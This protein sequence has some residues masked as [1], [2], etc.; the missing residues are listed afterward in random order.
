[1]VGP[2]PSGHGGVSQ[3]VRLWQSGGYYD[4]FSI[5]YFSSV[6]QD[7]HKV[8]TLL[9]NLFCFTLKC[10][11]KCRFVYV[12]TSSYNSFYRKSLFI[13]LAYLFNKKLVI[14][15]HPAFFSQF[16]G[17]LSG[18]KRQIA[19]LIFSK[20]KG[21]IVLT[22]ELKKNISALFPDKQIF[23]L[24]NP[25]DIEGMAN[26]SNIQRQSSHILYLGWYVK[27]KGVY[28]LVDAIGILRNKNIDVTADFY[29]T[30]E[31]DDLR[32]YVQERNL[33][34]FVHINGWI[35]LNEKL[36]ALYSCTMLVLPSHTEGVPNV[37]LEA[38]ATKTPIISTHVGGL[39]D[40][41]RD[42]ENA[43]IAESKNAEDL[44][45]KIC[46]IL[47]DRTLSEK[48]SKSAYEEAC[49]NHS[50]PVIKEHFRLIL[51]NLKL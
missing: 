31:G 40:V 14:H 42:R 35:G 39:K 29:G 16:L 48:I 19:M 34:D 6:S 45:D 4:E 38:M 1:M 25:V 11:V 10:F 3:V 12:H 37:I 22:P 44:S 8:Y 49:D 47:R 41:L 46:V 33:S 28:D 30:K 32:K 21:I 27:H 20:A 26:G 43:I 18:I 9:K 50:L 24:N 7:N 36:N 23:V 13:C 5:K 51:D 17:S 15:I 2:D